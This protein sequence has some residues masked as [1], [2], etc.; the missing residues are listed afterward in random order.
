MIN[1]KHFRNEHSVKNGDHLSIISRSFRFDIK[2]PAL[3]QANV[4]Q[5]TSTPD[6]VSKILIFKAINFNSIS[7]FLC[8]GV[9]QIYFITEE[10]FWN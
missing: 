3:K 9:K 4:P 8:A 5:L 7:L 10:D 2:E 1:G 6:Q